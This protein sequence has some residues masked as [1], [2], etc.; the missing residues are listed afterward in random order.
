[1]SM[2]GETLALLGHPGPGLRFVLGEH[3][4]KHVAVMAPDGRKGHGR[5]S[6]LDQAFS[7]QSNTREPV[8][9]TPCHPVALHLRRYDPGAGLIYDQKNLTPLGQIFRY[10]SEDCDGI[11][12]LE[13]SGEP[14]DYQIIIFDR[15]GMRSDD[16]EFL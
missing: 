7:K 4:R 5:H 3:R 11:L 9:E 13:I 16:D 2:G 6:M 12:Q 8:F 10:P 14:K 1:M 15:Q